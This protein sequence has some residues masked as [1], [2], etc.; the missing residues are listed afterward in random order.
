MEQPLFFVQNADRAI[1]S[2]DF[3]HLEP[4]QLRVHN[5]FYTLQGE[6]IFAGKPA[7]FLRLAGCNFGAK[8]PYCL[9]CDTSFQYDNGKDMYF[10]A[11]LDRMQADSATCNL[12]VVTGGEPS[13]QHTLPNFIDYALHGPSYFENMNGFVQLESNGTGVGVLRDCADV[14]SYVTIVVSPKASHKGYGDI[15][16]LIKAFEV[17]G[18]LDNLYLKYVVE[19]SPESPH[20]QVPP[21]ALEFAQSCPE[22]V[23][24]SPAAVYKRAYQGE[25]SNAWDST[26]IDHERTARNYSYAAELCLKH[27]LRLSIQQHLF[28]ALA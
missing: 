19:A 8:D 23:Y 15:S 27:S 25:V 1:T 22:H 13:L 14:S 21:Q 18:N 3:K 20:S 10:D 7:H 17:D 6:G 5:Q 9:F 24:L 4:N 26:L 2:K 12:I 16:P 28:C 11:V